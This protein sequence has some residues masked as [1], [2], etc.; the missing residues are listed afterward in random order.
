MEE[1]PEEGTTDDNKPVD[2]DKPITNIPPYMFQPGNRRGVM[3][4]SGQTRDPVK[5]AKSISTAWEYKK[6]RMQFFDCL[7]EIEL[8]DGSKVNFWDLCAKKIHR[9]LFADEKKM[10]EQ[11]ERPLSKKEKMK[12]ITGLVKEIMPRETNLNIKTDQPV[13][14]IIERDDADL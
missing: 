13:Q 12:L 3:F 5:H 1:K 6:A 11:G 9:E 10:R 2:N 7:S 14:V 8:P 4:G